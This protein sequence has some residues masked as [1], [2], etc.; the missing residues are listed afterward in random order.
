MN[1]LAT[2]FTTQMNLDVVLSDFIPF[3][4]YVSLLP[5]RLFLS[6]ILFSLFTLINHPYNHISNAPSLQYS[7][8]SLTLY[9]RCN[10]AFYIIFLSND[11]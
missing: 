1:G 8:S 5:S 11:K 3:T 10:N 4:I 6:P 2:V 9:P 7:Y